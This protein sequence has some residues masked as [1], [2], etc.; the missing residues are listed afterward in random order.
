MEN[1]QSSPAAGFLKAMGPWPLILL[2]MAATWF[3]SRQDSAV[4]PV[5][6]GVNKSAGDADVVMLSAEW[7]PYCRRARKFFVNESINYCE[8]DIET[9]H[10][11]RR[12]YR[13]SEIKVI[14]IIRIRDELLVGFSKAEILQTLAS[15]DLY[16]LEKL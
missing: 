9:S 15:Y 5:Y 10:T 3:M 6:C 11:G 12:L 1:R 8:H 2:V 7:C 13:E 14:P 16:P 4:D